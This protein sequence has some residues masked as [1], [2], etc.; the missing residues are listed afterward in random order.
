[1][2]QIKI[3][4]NLYCQKDVIIKTLNLPFVPYFHLLG[5]STVE[6]TISILGPEDMHSFY[7]RIKIYIHRKDALRLYG[8]QSMGNGVLHF[9]VV[10]PTTPYLSVVWV[11]LHGRCMVVYGMVYSLQCGWKQCKAQDIPLYSGTL[12]ERLLS[13]MKL[14]FCYSTFMRVMLES[15][16]GLAWCSCTK[17]YGHMYIAPN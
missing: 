10:T 13:E 7:Q 1:M 11:K 16:S 12:W 2:V 5:T 4:L 8:T 17:L 14:Q 6:D 15:W 9:H 3:C